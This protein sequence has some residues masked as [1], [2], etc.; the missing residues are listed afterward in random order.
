MSCSEC[1]LNK[2]H[3]LPFSQ[4]SIISTKP[5]EY[6]YTDVWSSPIISFDNFKYYLVLV[7]HFSRYTWLYPLQKKSQVKEVF[8]S[9]KSLVENKFQTKIGTLFSENGGEFIALRGFLS[10]NGITH[11]TS[12]PH[13]PEHNGL[14]ERKHRHVVETGLTLLSTASIPKEYWTFAFTTVIYLINRLLT[15]VLSLQS[16]FQKLFCT[17]PNYEKLRVFGCLCFP[18]LRPY[19]SLKLQDRSQRCVFLSYSPTQSDYVCLHKPSGQIYTSR[20]VQFNED[21]FSFAVECSGTMTAQHESSHPSN[22][23]VT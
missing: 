3:K 2:S 10:D 13:T 18:W 22:P 4:N 11:L 16:P 7:D 15:P 8:I 5:L 17:T 19:T 6:I 23:R 20:H 21:E 14:A 1:L 12:P 9:F